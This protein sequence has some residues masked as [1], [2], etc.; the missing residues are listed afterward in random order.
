[1]PAGVLAV[2]V[3]AGV[4]VGITRPFASRT[5]GG[6]TDNAYPTGLA[7]VSRQDLSSQTQVAATLGYAGRY[8]VV[9][10]ARGT[11]TALPREGQVVDEGHV[12]YRV[13]GQPVYL[14]Y[15]PVPAYRSLSAGSAGADVRELNADLVRL[16]Y[17]ARSELDPASDYFG[18]PTSQALQ[19]FQSA[20]GLAATGT[21]GLGQAVFLP[22]AVRVTAVAATLG[23]P[24]QPGQPVLSA[25]STRRTVTIAL[26]ASEQSEVAVGD[27]VTI[28]L[29]SDADT[30]GVV[31]SVGT[32]ATE[33]SSGGSGSGPTISVEVAPDDPAATGR[34][35]QAPVTVTITTARVT[36]ALVVP[37]D[38][39][40]ALVGGGYAVE[41]AG[42][43]GRRHLVRVFTGLFDDAAGL[44]QVTGSGLAVGQRVVVPAL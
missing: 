28:T 29:P 33:P 11:V 42:R 8:A 19:R 12:L 1:V 27:R 5:A 16:G 32:V 36:A 18:F 15:G 40:L 30:A 6:V 17:A 43:D 10:Q 13:S 31:S 38:A 24:A 2:V 3:V 23:G 9:N 39:L 35:D 14:L 21:L 41:V 34:W 25:S 26:D 37:V 7:A 44:V 4:A 22:A 20:R